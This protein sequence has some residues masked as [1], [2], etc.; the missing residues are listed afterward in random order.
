MLPAGLETG[1]FVMECAAK[2]PDVPEQPEDGFLH[3]PVP[4]PFLEGS[5]V[6]FV[7][8]VYEAL[9]E[10]VT[11]SSLKGCVVSGSKDNGKSWWLVWVLIK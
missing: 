3:F 4:V 7:R 5:T 6:M 10:Y 8:D 2:I 11:N 1:N 9:W